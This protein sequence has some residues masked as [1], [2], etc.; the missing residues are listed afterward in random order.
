MN[1]PLLRYCLLDLILRLI[2]AGIWTLISAFAILIWGIAIVGG[3]AIVL[4]RFAQ[5]ASFYN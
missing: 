5:H 1:T 2:H 4:A 3:A